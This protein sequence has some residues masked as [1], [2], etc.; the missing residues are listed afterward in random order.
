[1]R[2]FHVFRA[3]VLS[4]VLTFG[5]F[6]VI[7][8]TVGPR[9]VMAQ[10]IDSGAFQSII[11]DQM[12]AFQSGDAVRA[13][14]HAA[15]RLQQQFQTPD[16]FIQMVKNGY[17]PVY[18]P[19]NVIFGQSKATPHGPVQEVYVTGPKGQTWRAIYSF[20][21]QPDGTWRISG[22]YLTKDPGFSA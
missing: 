14:S 11:R 4:A 12:N 20:E 18:R 2:I 21:K 3:F 22:C 10:E 16:V 5:S 1:M 15:P 13:F 17:A 19:S 9:P 6:A 7:D 8:A